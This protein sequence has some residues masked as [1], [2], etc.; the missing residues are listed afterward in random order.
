[1]RKA[2]SVSQ[3]LQLSTLP[4]GERM[5]REV[6]RRVILA[7]IYVLQ[8]LRFIVKITASAALFNGQIRY[9]RFF[10]VG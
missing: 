10:G 5:V 1:M 9:A 8:N 3:L 7:M 2:D 6:S 4:R